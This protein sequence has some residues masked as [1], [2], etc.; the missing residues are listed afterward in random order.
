MVRAK[1]EAE[2]LARQLREK[3]IKREQK[4]AVVS[5]ER[6]EATAALAEA[7]VELK[8]LTKRLEKA[9]KERREGEEAVKVTRVELEK[10]GIAAVRSAE[11]R[12][13]LSV[14]LAAVRSALSI[15]REEA[16]ATS[17]ALDAARL[18]V[19]ERI[20]AMERLEDAV[21]A[22]SAHEEESRVSHSIATRLVKQ[23]N[24]E[25]K[26][27][28][29]AETRKV[30]RLE[31]ELAVALKAGA[32]PTARPAPGSAA[33]SSG[34]S[35]LIGAGGASSSAASPSAAANSTTTM[36]R[37]PPSPSL[38][39]AAAAPGLSPSVMMRSSSSG[40][41]GVALGVG[42]AGGGDLVETVKML[43]GRL[44]DVLAE[45]E[46]A[47]EK[48]KML[49][50]IVQSLSGELS[51]KRQLLRALTTSKSGGGWGGGRRGS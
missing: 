7:E 31:R 11:E 44:R 41:G 32:A 30:A 16:N 18:E 23:L 6:A 12:E 20:D 33:R 35:G 39:G 4:L 13:R 28:L 26:A 42:G 2:A 46:I 34:V 48:T 43:G 8:S 19:S 1:D 50:G 49:E 9:R 36:M 38:S 40:G 24:R 10:M 15:L 25:L 27:G 21:S 29:S 3:V 47:R 45:S 17:Y 14:D 51:D 37:P 5:T 22:A